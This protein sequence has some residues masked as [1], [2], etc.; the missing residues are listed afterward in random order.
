MSQ[1]PAELPAFT[2]N[3]GRWPA[4]RRIPIRPHISWSGP[5]PDREVDAYL[6]AMLLRLETA[7]P[8]ANEARDPLRQ[9]SVLTRENLHGIAI[10]YSFYRELMAA[11]GVSSIEDLAQLIK[12]AKKASVTRWLKTNRTAVSMAERELSAYAE[13]P[14]RK[15]FTAFG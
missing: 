11:Q 2:D 6:L 4:M 13:M 15:G 10:L 5:Q 8:Y 9:P 12:A 7:G 1:D 3:W 14:G